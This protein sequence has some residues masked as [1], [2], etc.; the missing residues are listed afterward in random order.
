[1]VLLRCMAALWLVKKKMPGLSVCVCVC[2][3]NELDLN[4][5]RNKMTVWMRQQ[6]REERE[7]VSLM[8]RSE[9]VE[10]DCPWVSLHHHL[11]VLTHLHEDITHTGTFLRSSCPCAATLAPA[12]LHPTQPRTPT[13]SRASSP[14]QFPHDRHPPTLPSI[15]T[16][17]HT[18]HTHY[19]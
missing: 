9:N 8:E 11:F 19:V 4:R 3:C 10:C 12:A 17:T 14:H 15:H 16:H 2:V 18:G 7:R 13:I 1:M 5:N 6:K